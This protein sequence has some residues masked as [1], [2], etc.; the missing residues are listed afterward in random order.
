MPP[1]RK[2]NTSPAIDLAGLETLSV[3]Q[4]RSAWTV[5]FGIE[6]ANRVSRELLVRA[7][8][9]RLQEKSGGELM[10]KELRQ[11]ER[12]AGGESADRPGSEGKAPAVTLR[13]GNRL[14]R[15]WQGRVHEVIVLDDQFL[16]KG[17]RYGSLSEIARLITGARWSGPRFFGLTGT[18]GRDKRRSKDMETADA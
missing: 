17:E 3:D 5:E 9:Y 11:L 6:P 16:W 2:K 8:A 15:E 12:L 7:V 1:G 13:P 10:P 18:A 4:L 14:V